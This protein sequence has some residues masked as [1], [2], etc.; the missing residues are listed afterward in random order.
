MLYF[1]FGFEAHPFLIEHIFKQFGCFFIEIFIKGPSSFC[2]LV[3]CLHDPVQKPHNEV[4]I[5]SIL[6]VGEDHITLVQEVIIQ[7][8]SIVNGL[9]ALID[10]FAY[11]FDLG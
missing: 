3:D 1:F 9:D 8:F 11:I 6:T 2:C 10:G 5:L 4:I 7:G